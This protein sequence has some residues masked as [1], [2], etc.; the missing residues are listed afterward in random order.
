MISCKVKKEKIKPSK[1]YICFCYWRSLVAALS[2]AYAREQ[3][4]AY[5]REQKLA[6]A[7]FMFFRLPRLLFLQYHGLEL[8]RGILETVN[9]EKPEESRILNISGSS[10][11]FQWCKKISKPLTSEPPNHAKISFK[12]SDRWCSFSRKDSVKFGG[13]VVF[14]LKGLRL[15]CTTWSRWDSTRPGNKHPWYVK[16]SF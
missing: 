10:F 3:K 5:A 13:R 11:S 15:S 6:Y 14:G 9:S 12:T 7:I 2:L 4:L 1:H 8:M 16:T